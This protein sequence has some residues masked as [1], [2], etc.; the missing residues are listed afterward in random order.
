MTAQETEE[1]MQIASVRII[2][3]QAIILGPLKS[4]IFW[5]V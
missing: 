1:T 5:M 3:E 4:S 2:V